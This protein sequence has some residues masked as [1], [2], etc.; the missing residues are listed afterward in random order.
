[1]ENKKLTTEQLEGL[2]KLQLPFK[3]DEIGKLPKPTKQQTEEVKKDYRT[4][5]RCKVCGGW[6]HAKVVHLDYVGHAALTKRLLDVDP[7][8]NWEPVATNEDG[9]PKFDK[10]GGMWGRLTVCGVTRLGY[11]D[12][13]KKQGPDATKEVIG[14]FLRNAAMRF[15]AALDLW[16]KE[17]LHKTANNDSEDNQEKP[18]QPDLKPVESITSYIDKFLEKDKETKANIYKSDALEAGWKTHVMP[19]LNQYSDSEQN[20]M[21]AAYKETLEVLKEDEVTE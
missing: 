17:D 5:I 4:G 14:D 16:S 2:K 18:Q 9:T 21:T 11:G 1:M 20:K 19:I 6:H 15:G 3:D 7:L 13:N 12:A 8:W 10:D